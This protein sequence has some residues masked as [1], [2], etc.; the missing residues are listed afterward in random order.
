LAFQPLA[1]V[2]TE[3]FLFTVQG[4]MSQYHKLLRRFNVKESFELTDLISLL[5]DIYS[6]VAGKRLPLHQLEVGSDNV[7][8]TNFAS[9]FE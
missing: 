6:S 8:Y 3:P 4:S 1:N 5:K 9:D 7:D 2:S